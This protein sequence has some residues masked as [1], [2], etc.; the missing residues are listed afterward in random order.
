MFATCVMEVWSLYEIMIGEG[1]ISLPYLCLAFTI[2][3]PDFQMSFW[4]LDFR[5]RD[6]VVLD[7]ATLAKFLFISI[8]LIWKLV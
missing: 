4:H 5:R 6:S 8:Q 3:L 7:Y 1:S 2:I